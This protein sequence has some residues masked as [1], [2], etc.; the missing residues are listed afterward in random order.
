MYELYA[1][2][3]PRSRPLTIEED[4]VACIEHAVR[5]FVH[6][7][8]YSRQVIDT[9]FVE[10]LCKHRTAVAVYAHTGGITQPCCT[11]VLV[12]HLIDTRLFHLYL[13]PIAAAQHRLLGVS[14]YN[15]TRGHC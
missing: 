9:A 7:E 8:T 12:G 4:I 5:A 10:I 3:R 14:M 2:V 15:S 13:Y 11:Q 1:V 6:V